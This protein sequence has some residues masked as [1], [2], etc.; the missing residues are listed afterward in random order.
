[1]YRSG[2]ELWHGLAKNATE[3]LGAPELIVPITVLLVFGQVLPVVLLAISIWLSPR[4]SFPRWP[5]WCVAT[6][7]PLAGACAVWPTGR[8]RAAPPGR[9]PIF[10]AIQWYAF[11]GLVLGRPRGWKGRTYGG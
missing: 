8:R 10:L 11:L 7:R 3:G 2:S 9:V 4:R 1:M 6:I 5:R